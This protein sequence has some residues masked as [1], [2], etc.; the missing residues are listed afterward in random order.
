M[1]L[2]GKSISE[3]MLSSPECIRVIR[4]N[5]IMTSLMFLIL[6]LIAPF[7]FL[8]A[9]LE[10]EITGETILVFALVVTVMLPLF[11]FNLHLTIK[12]WETPIRKKP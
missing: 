4:V 9:I 1:N 6:L 12:A 7:E 5:G 2:N 11:I 8:G 10:G 3:A